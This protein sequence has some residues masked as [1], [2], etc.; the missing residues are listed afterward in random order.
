MCVALVALAAC[1]RNSPE[2]RAAAVQQLIDKKDYRGAAV[3][4]KSALQQAPNDP[5]LRFQL[6]RVLMDSGELG[7]ALVE[8]SRARELGHPD[9]AVLPSL[10]RAL[11][12]AGQ[13]RVAIE[14][15][16]AV[17]LEDRAAQAELKLALALAHGATN[18]QA[19]SLEALQAALAINPALP[20]AQV[21]LANFQVSQ[22]QL[23]EAW[24]TIQK[25]NTAAPDNAG[26]WFTRA[27]LERHHRGDAKAAQQSLRRSLALEPRLLLA[28]TELLSLQYESGDRKGMREQLAAMQAAL[29]GNLNNLLFRAH[30]EYLDGNLKASRDLLQQLMRTN[31]KSLRVAMLAGQIDYRLG[32]L[33]LAETHLN[34]ALQIRPEHAPARHLLATIHMRQGQHAKVLQVLEP[35]LSVEP[36]DATALGIAGEA[37]MHLGNLARAQAFFDRASNARPDDQRLKAALA[38]SRMAAGQ[39]DQGLAELEA[40]ARADR[41]DFADLALISA[42]LRRGSTADA[43][44]AVERLQAKLPSQALPQ[45]L[46]GQVELAAGNEAAARAAWDAAL[47]IDPLYFPSATAL[48]ALDLSAGRLEDAQRRFQAVL[49]RDP[50]HLSAMLA[51]ADV[52]VRRREPAAVVAKVLQNAAQT[53]AGDIGARAAWVE[54][55]L[56][57]RDYRQAV[58]TAQ[59]ALAVLPDAPA[60][61]DLLGQAQLGTREFQQAMSTFRKLVTAVPGAADPHLRIAA[62]HLAQGDRAAARGSL[63]RALEVDPGLLPA[64]IQLVDLALADGNAREALTLVRSVQRARPRDPAGPLLE[65][66]VHESQGSWPAAVASYRSALALQPSTE[67]A[68]GLHRSLLRLGDSAAAAKHASDWRAAHANDAMFVLHLGDVALQGRRWAQAEAHYL[69]V[70]AALPESLQANNNLAWALIK[71]D[72]P[73]ATK[74]ARKAVSQAPTNS[75]LLDTLANAQIADGQAA[76]GLRTAEDALARDPSLQELRLTIAKASLR[77]GDKARARKEL[78]GLLYLGDRFAEQQEVAQLMRGL[79]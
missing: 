24:T 1:S 36:P 2:D 20:D 67:A 25:V 72:K 41:D 15:Y 60:L 11:T 63:R 76:E 44:M 53:H 50:T 38:L 68:V 66:R 28:H 14:R 5:A 32:S 8:L 75:A 58:T 9:A 56:R 69:E 18:Q 27:L 40:V 59:E 64:Q 7:G 70:L 39:V 52:M 12:M 42:L 10:A 21:L 65:A 4:L 6:G 79:Q 49:D 54:H 74:F 37:L 23:D 22:G 16:G 31:V 34:S 55:H 19:A 62:V 45:H 29:P 71:Q 78:E 46:R 30:I 57:Q 51:L 48:A 17:T 47:K 13:A 33:A 77:L 43:R 61:L 3:T 26:A 73:G 35:L